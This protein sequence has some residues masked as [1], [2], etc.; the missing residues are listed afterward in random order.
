MVCRDIGTE[1]IVWQRKGDKA[2]LS[3][4]EGREEPSTGTCM[5]LACIISWSGMTMKQQYHE[6]DD[7]D[8]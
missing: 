5:Y 6:K 4:Q 7:V 2:V 1:E 3:K 8:T